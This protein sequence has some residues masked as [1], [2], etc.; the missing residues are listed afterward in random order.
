MRTGEITLGDVAVSPLSVPLREPFVIASGRVDTTRAALVQVTVADARGQ[1]A[2]GLGESAALPPVTREDQPDLLRAIGAAGVRLQGATIANVDQLEQLL[3]ERLPAGA[4]ARAGVETAILD[5]AARLQGVP[6]H[7]ALGG[8]PAGPLITDITLSISDP[9]RMAAAAAR[10][11]EAGF[12]CF[13]VKVGRDWRADCASLRAV[14]AAVPGARFR[15]DANAGFTAGEALSLLDTALGDGLTIECYE[16]PCAAGDLKGMAEVAAQASVPVVADESFR[17][18][19]D[20]DRLL[21]ARAAGAVNLKLVKLGGPLAAVALARR[22]R[23]E[24]LL[25]MAGAMVETRVG[26]LAMAHVVAALDGVDWVDLDTAFL[27][28]H[29]PFQ[30]G[31]QA[32]GPE[33]RLL[34]EPGLGVGLIGSGD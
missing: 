2:T 21:A 8:G 29:D 5:A 3:V 16:Q 4:V 34:G 12:T 18:P 13:K 7:E 24:G 10:H 30:G 11:A 26:L 17:G 14:A 9:A 27:R 25:L 6:L 31:W 19:A 28:T 32:T 23:A 22:A 1:R 15:L 33:I 20:L